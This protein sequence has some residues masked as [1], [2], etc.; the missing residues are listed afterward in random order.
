MLSSE[1]RAA[2]ERYARRGTV[3]Q[4]LGL[5]ARI[6]LRCAAGLDNKT[7]AAEVGVWPGVVGKCALSP[8]GWKACWTNHDPAHRAESLM[9]KWSKS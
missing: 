4:Q 1:E 5:R 7:V 3:A 8:N 6:V 9:I 2:L